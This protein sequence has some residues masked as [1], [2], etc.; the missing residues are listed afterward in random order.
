MLTALPKHTHAVLARV[1]ANLKAV[2]RAEFSGCSWPANGGWHISSLILTSCETRA[3]DP[4]H[5]AQSGCP[6]TSTPRQSSPPRWSCT[7]SLDAK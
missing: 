5:W 6:S 4:R 7:R 2:R 3:G 1:E